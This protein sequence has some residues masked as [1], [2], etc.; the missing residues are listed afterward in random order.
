[1]P[2]DHHDKPYDAGTLKK[3]E[4]YT[5]FLQAWIQVFLHTK[6]FPGPL[7]IF[8]FFSGPGQDIAGSPGSP[9]IL[10]EELA[11]HRELV[12]KSGRK[13]EI[14]FNDYDEKKSEALRALCA[15]KGYPFVPKIESEDFARS[16]ATH[17][18]EI[19]RSPSFVLLDQFGVKFMTKEIFQYLTKCATTD[20]LFFFASSSQRRFSAQ[21]ANELHVP[22]ET[23]YWDVHRKVADIYRGW[24]PAK[25][26]VGQYSIM[27]GSNIY[28]L[29]FGSRH[30]LGM[31]KFLQTDSGEEA[32]YEIEAPAKQGELF[33]ERKLT[34]VEKLAQELEQAIR[35]GQLNTD[36]EV[37]YH[38]LTQGVLPTKVAPDLYKKL[39]SEGFLVHSRA[40]QPRWSTDA[41][42][43]PRVLVR[44]P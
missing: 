19:G 25:Y 7:R 39:K 10:M 37:A 40:Q 30:W 26:F 38:C 13:I 35:A 18:S 2:T 6:S 14:L 9:I 11:R 3:L 15:T 20:I 27:K 23:P 31:A 32:N 43:E 41:I 1:M 8:D 4:I 36:G 24:A 16:F 28:G 34:K 22:P 5:R 17:K 29:I 33:G 42:N 12:S 21:F 44:R